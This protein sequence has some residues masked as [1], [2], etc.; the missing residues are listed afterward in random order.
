MTSRLSVFILSLSL[1]ACTTPIGSDE[2][3]AEAVRFGVAEVCLPAS[4]SGRPASEIIET[5]DAPFA[6]YPLDVPPE[7][8]ARGIM[9]IW[10]LGESLTAVEAREDDMCLVINAGGVQDD[11]QAVA[12]GVIEQHAD[13]FSIVYRDPPDFGLA[14]ATIYCGAETEESAVVAAVGGRAG[15]PGSTGLDRLFRVTP[16]TVIWTER[17]SHSCAAIADG[18][19]PRIP[20][21]DKD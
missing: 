7:L 4:I 20:G 18:A 16:Q 6:I 8:A 12:A 1:C 10:R 11:V 19:I 14:R 13:D 17:Y 21:A 3:I 15:P 2:E 5:A 9:D